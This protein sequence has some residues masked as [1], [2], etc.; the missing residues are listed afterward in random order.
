MPVK[1]SGA[2]RV[3]SLSAANFAGIRD[4]LNEESADG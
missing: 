3:T 4:P 1:A 2:T